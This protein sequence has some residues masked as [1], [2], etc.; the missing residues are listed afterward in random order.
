MRVCVVCNA[1]STMSYVATLL[2]G[3]AKLF[4]FSWPYL[5]FSLRRF[6]DI[7]ALQTRNAELP[8]SRSV[9]EPKLHKNTTIPTKRNA[10]GWQLGSVYRD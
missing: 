9:T 6:Y 2:A 5:F 10:G 4:S 7:A 1:Y 3:V 8:F